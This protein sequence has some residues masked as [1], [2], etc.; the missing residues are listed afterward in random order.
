MANLIASAAVTEG[1]SEP[2][3]AAEATDSQTEEQEYT[4]E[5]SDKSPQGEV[6]SFLQSESVG[7]QKADR[8]M[9]HV[10]RQNC[11]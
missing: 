1:G 3:Q 4:L 7:V 11:A 5:K 6:T 2:A 8:F 9:F 10:L